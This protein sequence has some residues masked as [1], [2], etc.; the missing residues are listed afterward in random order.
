LIFFIFQIA[1]TK[2]GLYRFIS[3]FDRF[4][5]GFTDKPISFVDG[6]QMEPKVSTCMPEFD[7]NQR[8]NLNGNV[9]YV[10]DRNSKVEESYEEHGIDAQNDDL[11]MIE[12]HIMLCPGFIPAML[13]GGLCQVE[14]ERCALPSPS[15]RPRHPRGEALQPMRSN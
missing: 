1:Q 2:T 10:V 8:S 12:T 6:S 15:P 7:V 14:T 13:D 3:R 4:T 11:E 9:E 5:S